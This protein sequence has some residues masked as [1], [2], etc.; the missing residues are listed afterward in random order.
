[1]QVLKLSFCGDCGRV[2]SK[3]VLLSQQ[4]TRNGQVVGKNFSRAYLQRRQEGTP[5]VYEFCEGTIW[6]TLLYLA[7]T[8]KDGQLVICHTHVSLTLVNTAWNQTK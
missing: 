2:R 8:T 6:T 3:R 4:S 5:F 1:M 7:K